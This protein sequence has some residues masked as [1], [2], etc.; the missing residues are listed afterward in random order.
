MTKGLLNRNRYWTPSSK[1]T[2]TS[3]PFKVNPYRRYEIIISTEGTLLKRW[4]LS[5]VLTL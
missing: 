2:S 4:L 5:R 3:N 1:T